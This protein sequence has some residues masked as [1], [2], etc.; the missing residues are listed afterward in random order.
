M[1]EKDMP[2]LETSGTPEIVVVDVSQ[3]TAFWMLL[4]E[5]WTSAGRATEPITK[6]AVARREGRVGAERAAVMR[7]RVVRMVREYMMRDEIDD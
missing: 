3:V 2:P 5:A 1:L 7:V 6:Q 4:T